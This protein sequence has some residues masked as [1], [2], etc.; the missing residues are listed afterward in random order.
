MANSFYVLGQQFYD[1]A[2]PR[3]SQ[4]SH[5]L[6]SP[7]IPPNPEEGLSSVGHCSH[8][9]VGMEH[10]SNPTVRGAQLA[11]STH[12]AHCALTEMLLRSFQNASSGCHAALR[13]Y[14][15]QPPVLHGSHRPRS[16]AQDSAPTPPVPPPD[17]TDPLLGTNPCALPTL[18]LNLRN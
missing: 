18:N 11:L 3:A 8:C 5:C 14:F 2:V 12:R 10:G 13:V 1:P 6:S 4:C 15:V 9:S 16:H 7:R 17:P